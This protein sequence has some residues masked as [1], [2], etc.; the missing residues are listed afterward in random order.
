MPFSKA[1]TQKYDKVPCLPD[2]FPND[3]VQLV[4]NMIHPKSTQRSTAEDARSALQKF[5]EDEEQMI[6]F[7]VACRQFR[8]IEKRSK[9]EYKS[10]DEALV[11]TEVETLKGRFL[12]KKC[13]LL[14]KTHVMTFSKKRDIIKNLDIFENLAFVTF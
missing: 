12:K 11:K 8:Q 13:D 1:I 7:E 3:F 10:I 5:E 2:Y 4:M 14:K 9:Y 6:Q